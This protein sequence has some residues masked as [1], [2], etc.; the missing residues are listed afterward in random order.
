MSESQEQTINVT[1]DWVPVDEFIKS[2]IGSQF[3]KSYS[4]FHWMLRKHRRRLIEQGALVKTG[5]CL[6]VSVS[7]A[8]MVIESIF[9]EQTLASLDRFA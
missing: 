3:F 9:R 4:S 2:S 8:P 1:A 7:R 5:K 6:A